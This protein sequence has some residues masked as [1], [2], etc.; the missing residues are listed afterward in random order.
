[1]LPGLTCA[2]VHLQSGLAQGCPLSCVLYV[3]AV[4]PFLEFLDKHIDEVELVA[5]FCDDWTIECTT[6]WA[7][8]RVQAVVEEFERA[9]GQALNRNKSKFVPTREITTTEDQIIRCRWPN[10]QIVASAKLLGLSIGHSLTEQDH[11]L[12]TE[13][14]YSERMR[15]LQAM[16][17]SWATKLT[18]I[19]V[20]MR[21][22]FG[23]V[24]RHAYCRCH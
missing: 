8:P 14:R 15:I 3:I 16:P 2:P 5:G 10:C 13:I 1:M 20:F 6:V 11:G 9:S 18:T 19:N 7:V 12:E 21:S 17:A 24:A 4:D 23:Y 22:L